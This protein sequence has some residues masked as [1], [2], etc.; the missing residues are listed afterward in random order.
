MEKTH[1]QRGLFLTF[2]APVASNTHREYYDLSNH[3]N[4]W[5]SNGGK[6]KT[7][8]VW[9]CRKPLELGLKLK[10]QHLAEFCPSLLQ[11]FGHIQWMD[12][13]RIPKKLN[14]WKPAHGKWGSGVLKTSWWAVMQ[15][16]ISKMNLGWT[17]EEAEVAAREQIM[18]RYLSNLA[19]S[20]VMH[21]A[22]Q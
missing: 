9:E 20:A 2:R 11:W 19:V 6:M 8:A 7:C 21:D 15:K 12:M 16:D 1:C 22:N 4:Y 13:A 17:V 10:I 18:W 5:Q 3:W 14:L